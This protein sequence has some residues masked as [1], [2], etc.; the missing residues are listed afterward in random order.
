[1]QRL[2]AIVVID[3][4]ADMLEIRDYIALDDPAAANKLMARFAT[5]FTLIADFPNIGRKSKRKARLR[6]H[7][8]RGYV[9]YYEVFPKL[10][11]VKVLRV[12]HGARRQ[13][14]R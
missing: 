10:G 4:R 9:I 5:A 12:L 1:M 14:G 3:A 6:R 11:F 2:R 13:L 7:I 8:V